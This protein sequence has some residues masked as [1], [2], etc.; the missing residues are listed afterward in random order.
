MICRN[1]GNTIG[2]NEKFCKVCGAAAINGTDSLTEYTAALYSD[3]Q[4]PVSNAPQV[5]CGNPQMYQDTPPQTV[6]QNAPA[7]KKPKSR[8][9]LIAALFVVIGLLLA[10][11]MVLLISLGVTVFFKNRDTNA[12]GV[13]AGDY[14][15]L[16]TG[17]YEDEMSDVSYPDAEADYDEDVAVTES[18]TQDDFE[19]ENA[20][21]S[22]VEEPEDNRIVLTDDLQYD[23]NIFLSNFS[24]SDVESFDG[25]PSDKALLY[26]ALSYNLINRNNLFESVENPPKDSLYWTNIR[27]SEKYILETIEKYFAVKKYPGFAADFYEGYVDGYYYD[28][29][30]GGYLC[31][32]FSI[33]KEVNYI[34]NNRY[35][36]QFDIYD[37][38]A[39]GS[40]YYGFSLEEIEKDDNEYLCYLGKGTAIIYASDINDRSTYWLDEYSVTR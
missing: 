39:G 20:T 18:P 11:I 3:N 15:E 36:L 10:V 30:T 22:S 13:F 34:G 23:V 35:E 32:G 33:V 25:I 38:G 7:P 12:E 1:C 8:K 24:E 27:I 16:H 31:S 14:S 4:M 21:T 26:Y 28:Q 6:V 29:F 40:E 2:D 5:P 17:H 19:I 37:D 9:G